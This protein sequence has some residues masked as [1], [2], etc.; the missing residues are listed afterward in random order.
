MRKEV[1]E[2]PVI[3]GK[4]GW[5]WICPN[6]SYGVV[7][8]D[9]RLLNKS[10]PSDRYTYKAGDEDVRYFTRTE[11]MHQKVMRAIQ[12]LPRAQP[13]LQRQHDRRWIDSPPERAPE[14]RKQKRILIKKP[15]A[16][17]TACRIQ[18]S[19]NSNLASVNGFS[20]KFLFSED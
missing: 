17:P 3:Y 18:K 11:F 6:G 1:V 5:Y 8:T 16:A 19:T 15:L 10:F 4:R 13:A 9:Y 12:V 2:R 14:A 20:S 7:I